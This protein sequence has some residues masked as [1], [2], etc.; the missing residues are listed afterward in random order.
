MKTLIIKIK[1][2][3]DQKFFLS[4]LKAEHKHK[5]ILAP[6]TYFSLLSFSLILPRKTSRLDSRIN[7]RCPSGEKKIQM[8]DYQLFSPMATHFLCNGHGCS[9]SLD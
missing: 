9:P 2:K 5:Q 1:L 7:G 4:D 3:T 6:K 8:I